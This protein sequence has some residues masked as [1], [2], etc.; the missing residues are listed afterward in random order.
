[1]GATD[2]IA[3]L[4]KEPLLKSIRPMLQDLPDD[5]W[6]LR[7]ELAPAV[8][9]V[10]AHGLR[11]DVLILPRHLPH[12]A[13]FI[14]RHPTLPMV[15]DHG[16]KP[17]IARGDIE[18]WRTELRAIAQDHPRLC[19]KLSGLV[20]EAAPGWTVEMLKP[21]VGALLDIFG[22]KRLMWGSDWPV[23]T[24]NGDYATW[25]QAAQQL[26]GFLAPEERSDIFG[27]TA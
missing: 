24:L 2:D 26:T 16:A 6:I 14:A 4:A 22:P 18:P 7:P 20:T 5:D 25:Y 11:F 15:I 13:K 12:I 3:A 1:S 10:E 19:C 23:L 17:K 9:A 21:Y 8:K 27:G